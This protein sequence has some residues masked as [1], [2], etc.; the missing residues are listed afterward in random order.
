LNPYESPKLLAEYLLLHFGDEE[1]VLG[2]L[3]GP[4]DAVGFPVR[5]V[6]ELL[7]PVPVDARALDLGCA[8]GGSSFG[9]A[10]SCGEVL[11]ID[12]SQSFIDAATR[13]RDSGEHAFQKAI[14]GDISELCVA[15]VPTAI[16][17]KRVI[18]EQGDA[19]D[20]QSNRKFSIVLAANLLCRLPDPLRLIERLPALVM[21]GGQL[22][23][24]T[25][26]T[27]LEEFT[28][29]ENWIGGTAASG[30]S[31]DALRALLEPHF[32][33][34]HVCD[35]PFLIR[36]HARKFQYGVACGSRWR[37]R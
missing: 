8:V 25:P 10:R 11:G 1:D 12:F 37:R 33:L 9:L 36:E 3:P 14:E 5:L 17:R 30:R 22:L 29:K 23:L 18:F 16:D 34:E 21:P 35:L 20:F 13:L 4:T 15:R 27:W 19:C 24:T 6:H 7:A 26:F 32:T 31:F 2:G 28:P